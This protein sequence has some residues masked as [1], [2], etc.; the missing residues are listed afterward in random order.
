MKLIVNIRGCNGAGKSTIP[1]SMLDDPEMYVVTK[2]YKGKD[3]G[4]L[5]V[6]PTYG[7]VALGT[8]KNKTGG[9]DVFP[10]NE[11]THKAFWYAL[12]KFPEY[13]ILM[14]GVI[15]STIRST[16]VN[17]FNEAK[18]K[19]PE[20]QVLIVNFIPPLEVCL[21][22]VQLRNGGKAINESAVEQKWKIINRNVQKFKDEGF[23]SLRVDNSK[24]SKDK[25]LKNFLKLVDK[26]R[27]QTS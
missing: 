15:A 14:E 11:L 24:C 18:E 21:E 23:I 16:Y 2:P 4:I 3:K 10:N 20:R 1:M 17:L 6:F 8:Y 27:R 13:D 25:M 7:W 19:Y 26:Y 5:T 12:K 22:R 9:L